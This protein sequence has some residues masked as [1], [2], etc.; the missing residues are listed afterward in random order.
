MMADQEIKTLIIRMREHFHYE[1]VTV[2]KKEYDALSAK[3]KQD[4]VDY[5][6]AQGIGTKLS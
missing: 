5:F 6:N 3:D 4:L 2:L 1:Q